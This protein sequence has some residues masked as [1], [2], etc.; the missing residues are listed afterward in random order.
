MM[1]D[2]SHCPEVERVPGRVSG[3]WVVRNTRILADALIENAD[4]GYT[5]EEL[6][7]LFQGLEIEPTKRILDFAREH[8]PHPA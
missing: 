1:L 2:W 8:A 4:D 6:I 7:E 5:A 3:Q